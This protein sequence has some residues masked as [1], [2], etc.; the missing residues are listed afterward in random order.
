MLLFCA[1]NAK[2]RHREHIQPL[3]MA[4]SYSNSVSSNHAGD[5]SRS[6]PHSPV[7]RRVSST[8][9]HTCPAVMPSQR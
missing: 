2:Q 5:I 9:A 1:A 6:R 4:L 8:M 7:H 3:P